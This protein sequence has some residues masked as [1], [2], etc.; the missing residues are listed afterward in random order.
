MLVQWIGLGSLQFVQREGGVTHRD[1]FE[2]SCI[3]LFAYDEC[4]YE[5]NLARRGGPD[6][7][8]NCTALF[9]KNYSLIVLSE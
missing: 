7:V 2:V 5:K 9:F 4:G 3:E 6:Q 1:V 8:K